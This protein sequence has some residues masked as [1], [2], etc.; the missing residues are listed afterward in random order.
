MSFPCRELGGGGFFF[1]TVEAGCK[2]T[3][4]LLIKLTR[5]SSPPCSD[6]SREVCGV[7]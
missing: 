3:G 5:S 4:E 1:T 2:A 7:S 6:V